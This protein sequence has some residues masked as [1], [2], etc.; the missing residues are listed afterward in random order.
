VE[1]GLAAVLA[2]PREV[3]DR[4]IATGRRV[5]AMPGKHEDNANWNGHKPDQ[6]IPPER[7]EDSGSGGGDHEK[8]EDDG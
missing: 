8:N 6:G 3:P 7:D 5:A 1:T 4:G 2:S